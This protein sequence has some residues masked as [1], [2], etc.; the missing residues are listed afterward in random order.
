[1][2][3]TARHH[4]LSELIKT[5]QVARRCRSRNSLQE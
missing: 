2:I 3:S 4:V 5:R 1:V